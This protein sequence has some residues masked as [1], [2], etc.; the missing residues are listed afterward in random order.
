MFIPP[1]LRAQSRGVTTR[2][3]RS[4]TA[5]NGP[6]KNAYPHLA[7]GCNGLSFLFRISSRHLLFTLLCSRRG[8]E[9]VCQGENSLRNTISNKEGMWAS[10]SLIPLLLLL[11]SYQSTVWYHCSSCWDPTSKP[12]GTTATGILPVQRVVQLLLILGSYHCS[13]HWDSTT[14]P[15]TGT[16]PV[17][18]HRVVP[19]RLLSYWDP[20]SPPCGT[21]QPILGSY[22]PTVW[23]HHGSSYWD[24]TTAPH[25][26]ILPVCGS[27]HVDS[28]PRFSD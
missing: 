12:F 13:S 28:C 14:A 1:W 2:C 20:T 18:A 25:T 23:Y 8:L 24:P 5:I 17:P 3:V 15:H 22:Q 10:S 7:C 6:I 19:P 9:A 26:G 11:G 4:N 16:L 21:A 27:S